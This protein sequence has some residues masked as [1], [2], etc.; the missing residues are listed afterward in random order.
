MRNEI[1]PSVGDSKLPSLFD[2]ISSNEHVSEVYD[3]IVANYPG[4]PHSK[5]D[6]LWLLRRATDIR[7]DN[8]SPEKMLEKAVAMLAARNHMP[9]WYNQCPVASGI[10]NSRSDRNS[11][12]D[13]VECSE[14]RERVR[15]VELKWDSDTPL[16][17][18][19]QILRYGVAYIFCRV[20]SRELPLHYRSLMDARHVS[21]EVVAPRG[22]FLS[23]ESIRSMTDTTAWLDQFKPERANEMPAIEFE[24]LE[25][26]EH[27]T[28][29]SRSL[30]EFARMKTDGLLS[31]SL[32]AFAFP[33]DFNRI[34]FSNGHEVRV[35]CD[36]LRLSEEGRMVR[37]AFAG[38]TPVR[39]F[40]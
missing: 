1:S 4:A 28:E 15:F 19:Q 36:T 17:A 8:S 18:I 34:P 31:M 6:A 14:S 10:V 25:L 35:K 3:K 22:Y 21:L 13:L 23:V 29:Q 16:S 12:V 9:G 5:S 7:S 37:D 39:S 24:S 33:E 20:Y 27:I 2:G 38:L 32:N 26:G 30:N 40:S 11:A